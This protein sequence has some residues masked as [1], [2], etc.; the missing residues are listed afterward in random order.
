MWYRYMQLNIH[1]ANSSDIPQQIAQT[2]T[3]VLFNVFKNLE[4]YLHSNNIHI[5]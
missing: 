2:F 3:K 5:C 4:L 1:I